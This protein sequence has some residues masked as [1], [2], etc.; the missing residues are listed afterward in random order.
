MGI[1]TVYLHLRAFGD[2]YY[3]SQLFPPAAAVGD[4]DP[5]PI[6][7]EEAHRLHLSVHGWINPLRLQNDAGMTALSDRYQ[8]GQWYRDSQKTAPISARS[9]IT[10]G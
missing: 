10:G 6:L 4:F 2:A 7:L 3:C 5:L 8:I 1:N 9:A